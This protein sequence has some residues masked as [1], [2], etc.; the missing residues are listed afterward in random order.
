MWIN[1]G[2]V[3]AGSK[4]TQIVVMIRNTLFVA[5]CK[6]QMASFVSECGLLPATWYLHPVASDLQ[7]DLCNY[8][9]IP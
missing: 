9:A 4:M 3:K 2:E 1:L 7:A 5:G 6:W 8:E